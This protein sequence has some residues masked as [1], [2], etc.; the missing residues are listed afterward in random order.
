MSDAWRFVAE[1]PQIPTD[2]N[3]IRRAVMDAKAMIAE[4]TGHLNDLMKNGSHTSSDLLTD[5][6]KLTK[7]NPAAAAQVMINNPELSSNFCP[8]L[9]QASVLSAKDEKSKFWWSMA[10]LA[11][12]TV[13]SLIL[14]PVGGAIIGATLTAAPLVV[15]ANEAYSN[16]KFA[17]SA[18][19]VTKDSANALEGELEREKFVNASIGAAAAA[20]SSFLF[21]GLLAKAKTPL[22]LANTKQAMVNVARASEETGGALTK[23][24]LSVDEIDARTLVLGESEAGLKELTKNVEKNPSKWRQILERLKRWRKTKI[25][26]GTL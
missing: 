25:C 9:T 20:G 8:I 21:A 14:P 24:L 13:V 15:E 23:V 1:K 18:F 17:S 16:Y 5:L 11:G 6:A 2:P 26:G 4:Q 19:F 12:G 22:Q 3:Y 10:F 7:T